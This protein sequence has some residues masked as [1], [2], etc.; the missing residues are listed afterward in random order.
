MVKKAKEEGLLE[1]DENPEAE[2]RMPRDVEELKEMAEKYPSWFSNGQKI[3]AEDGRFVFVNGKFLRIDHNFRDYIDLTIPQI[4]YEPHI[5][6]VILARARKQD[7]F[8]ESGMLMPTTYQV[9]VQTQRGLEHKSKPFE[10]F[11]VVKAGKN[12]SKFVTGEEDGI[13]KGDEIILADYL[14]GIAEFPVILDPCGVVAS[15]C[16][17]LHYSEV[18]GFIK[19]GR[20]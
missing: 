20:E 11:F 16:I 13:Q 17:S 6:R 2:V 7:Q 12:F 1:L 5:D 9:P 19:H 10:R 4:S 14:K 8:D 18:V 15:S 3:H